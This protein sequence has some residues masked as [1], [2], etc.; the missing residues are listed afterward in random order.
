MSIYFWGLSPQ[1]LTQFHPLFGWFPCEPY[2]SVIWFFSSSQLVTMEDNGTEINRYMV[3]RQVY[4]FSYSGPETID[5]KG[6]SSITYINCWE[7]YPF[8]FP[9]FLLVIWSDS[10]LLRPGTRDQRSHK[11]PFMRKPYISYNSDRLPIFTGSLP[12][13]QRSCESLIP[14]SKKY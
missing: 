12:S 4:I 11:K 7:A 6:I 8:I 9:K 3:I 2:V 5:W 13:E 14:Y 1:Y 10:I